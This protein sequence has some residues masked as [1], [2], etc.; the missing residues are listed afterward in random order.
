MARSEAVGLARAGRPAVEAEDAKRE[1]CGLHEGGG[2][3]LSIV[4]LIDSIAT[5]RYIATDRFQ[6]PKLVYVCGV[7]ICREVAPPR[8]SDSA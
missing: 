2:L 5:A 8:S 1:D 6:G 3:S 7:S 4:Q